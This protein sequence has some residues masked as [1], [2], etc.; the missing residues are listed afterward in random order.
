MGPK[1]LVTGATGQIGSELVPALRE[2]YGAESVVAGILPG[3]KPTGLGP[4]PL[5]YFD[6]TNS[7][8]VLAVLKKHRIQVVYHL[9]AILSAVAESKPQLAWEVNIRGLSN[10]LE[11]AAEVGV[12]RVFWPS[13]VAVFGLGVPKKPAPQD[14]PLVPASTYGITKVAGELLCNYYS[15]KHHVDTRCIRYPG[16]ISSKT[17]PGGGTT[18]YAVEMF[19]AAVLGNDYTSFLSEDT[20][21]PMMYMP[22]AIS[23][24]LRLMEVEPA[25]VKTHLG[26]NVGAMS[27]TPGQL[28][29]SIR[30]RIP[31]FSCAYS[32]DARQKIAESWPESV[33]DSQARKDWGWSPTYDLPRTTDD[34]ILKLADRL[35]PSEKSR[36]V[37][38]LASLR[39]SAVARP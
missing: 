23:A 37:A 29:K 9:A 15:I 8:A 10:I 20:A 14:A 32:P 27:F 13:S 1:I 33:D 30:R 4:G 12:S 6:V 18:D 5:E 38:L 35:P 28:A 7:P 22:D 21:L 11:G 25:R 31:A 24:A 17:R 26:Y 3:L 16:L 19:E 39:G 34:M 2:K 36:L